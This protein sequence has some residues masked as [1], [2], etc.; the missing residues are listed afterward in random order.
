[1]GYWPSFF[2]QDGWILAKFFF[3]HVMAKTVRPISSHLAQTSLVDKRFIWLSGKFFLWETAPSPERARQ[4]HLV[5]S[6]SQSQCRIWFVL[7][8]EMNL[9]HI[10]K[11][12]ALLSWEQLNL[13]RHELCWWGCFQYW[14]Y[15]HYSLWLKRNTVLLF[16]VIFPLYKIT[17]KLKETWK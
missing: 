11:R 17:F 7:W 2:S 4:L 8:N 9:I 6:G 3:M 14:H 13:V 12:T 1:M 5:H 10:I 15:F 16:R